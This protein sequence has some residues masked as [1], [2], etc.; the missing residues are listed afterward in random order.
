MLGLGIMIF[1][2]VGIVVSTALEIKRKE[3]IYALLM[4]IFPLIFAIG[5]ALYFEVI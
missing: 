4:K 1:G 5:C 3:P 2:A